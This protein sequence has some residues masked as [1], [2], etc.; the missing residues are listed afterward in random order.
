LACSAPLAGLSSALWLGLISERVAVDASRAHLA[1][2]SPQVEQIDAPQFPICV[3][4]STAALQEFVKFWI[5]KW[6]IEFG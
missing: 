1:T 6:L 2:T 3:T 4:E 5:L